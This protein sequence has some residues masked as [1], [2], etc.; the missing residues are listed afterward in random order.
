MTQKLAEKVAVITGATSGMALAT[1]RLFV[2]EGG[3]VFITGRRQK[4]LDT[5]VA[6]IGANVIGVQGDAG[7]LEDV[8]RL[9]EVV[10]K[11]KGHIDILYASAGLGESNV[12]LGAIT[13][14]TFDRVMDVN[15]RGTLFT[16][17]KA[18]PLLREGGSILMTGSVAGQK[19]LPGL[20]VYNASKAAIRSFARTW[21]AELIA[22]KIRVN[23]LSPGPID[24]A[25]FADAPQQLRD[26]FTSFVPMARFGSPKEI[27]MAALFLASDDSSFITGTELCVDGGWAQ[28]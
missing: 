13:E 26:Q 28:V 24:T 3:F 16:V 6:S 17:Q 20:S 4:E 19:G 21:A 18:L 15:V 7:K 22:R 12:P 25:V 1:A 8:D 5:A 9:F 23:V 11:E 10:R 2:Q 27:A 14:E